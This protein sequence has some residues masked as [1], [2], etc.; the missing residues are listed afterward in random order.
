MQA[1]IDVNAKPI[2]LN[3]C[4][5]RCVTPLFSAVWTSC[6]WV[7]IFSHYHFLK[8]I[9]SDSYFLIYAETVD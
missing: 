1:E 4:V 6:E 2:P 8:L 7:R 3:D 5:S 9:M